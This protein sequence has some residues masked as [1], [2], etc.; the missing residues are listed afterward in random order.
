MRKTNYKAKVKSQQEYISGIFNNDLS[1]GIE[2]TGTGKTYL[3]VACA[4]YFRKRFS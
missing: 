3:A 1:F 2:S 4:V